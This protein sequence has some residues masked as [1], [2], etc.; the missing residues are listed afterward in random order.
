MSSFSP[1]AQ[2]GG[3]MAVRCFLKHSCLCLSFIPCP[4]PSLYARPPPLPSLPQVGAFNEYLR[5]A[6]RSGFHNTA[7]KSTRTSACNRRGFTAG[8]ISST[9]TGEATYQSLASHLE[10]M[11]RYKDC[12]SG[13]FCRFTQT[14][15]YRAARVR[16]RGSTLEVSFCSDSSRSVSKASSDKDMH[17]FFH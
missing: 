6:S 11:C 7:R 9:Q 2:V 5:A 4:S 10:R 8:Y 17:T 3:W 1:S 16:L 12:T 13:F 15:E 14:G